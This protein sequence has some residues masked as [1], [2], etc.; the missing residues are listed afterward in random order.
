MHTENPLP[1]TRP[2][3]STASSNLPESEPHR[4]S[5]SGQLGRV[6][7][8]L[9]LSLSAGCPI[10]SRA[11]GDPYAGIINRLKSLEGNRFTLVTRIGASRQGRP[12]YAVIATDPDGLQ[13]ISPGR[14]RI[15][16]LCGQ[17]GNEPAPVYSA[18][19][20]I[21]K[22]AAAKRRF[23]HD[24]LKR[25][26][27]AFVPVVNPDGFA[28]SG[29]CSS[30]GVDLN[31]DWAAP[32]Q[33]E[34]L[35]V[36]RL[37]KQF[38]P[39]VLLDE[40]E[41]VDGEPYGRSCIEVAR[42][43]DQADCRLARLLANAAKVRVSHDDLP[44]RSA[45]YGPESDRR[46][47]HRWFT[48]CGI[49]SMLVETSSEWPPAIRRRA[50]E[51]LVMGLA[52]TL[53]SGSDPQVSESLAGVVRGQPVASPLLA[54][55]YSPRRGT[56]DSSGQATYCWLAL[57]AGVACILL[58]LSFRGVPASRPSG[59]WSGRKVSEARVF[60]IA[61]AAGSDLSVRAR[62]A[63]IQRN[64]PRPTDRTMTESKEAMQPAAGGL[65]VGATPT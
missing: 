60:S 57:L 19:D 45:Y 61:E 40:H 1:G 21:E 12:L 35:A 7:I 64:R 20:L 28:A 47:A 56:P 9:G 26:V 42:S 10:P 37:V 51:E 43:G 48:S 38:R 52:A 63:L 59:A 3:S 58:C 46:L 41:W 22:L 6:L 31:R 39:H 13:S 30:S 44:L 8:V 49:C 25:V 29:R 14:L 4:R 32:T 55:L 54:T 16:V 18:L 36:S 5:P 50:Y 17:H 15:L 62:L 2:G 53:V 23:K 33:P 11:A 65:A 27:I 34:T 24:I